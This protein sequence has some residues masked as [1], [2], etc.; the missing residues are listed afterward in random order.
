MFSQIRFSKLLQ[1]IPRHAFNKAV[2]DS[3]GDRYAK[4]FSSWD[5]LVTMIFGQVNQIQSLRTLSTAFGSLSAHHYHLNARSMSRSTLSDALSK[6]SP[7]PLRLLCEHL[8][9]GVARKQR[10]SIQEKICLIDSTSITLRGPGFDEWAKATKTRITQGLKVHMAIDPRQSAPT[11][12]NVTYANVNDMTDAQG[13][14]LEAD[15]TYVFD[16][17]Y[18]DYSWWHRIDQSGAFFVTRL[19]RNANVSHVK[20]HSSPTEKAENIERDEVVQFNNRQL[21]GRKNPYK[22]QAVR[23]IQ[24]KRDDHDPP[25]ILVTND[26]SRSAAEIAALYKDRWQIE[27]F[28]KWLK[29]KLNLK[30]YLGFSENAVRIQIYSALITYLLMTVY[31][32]RSDYQGSISEL[33][34][35]LAHC[36]FERPNT[37]HFLQL[38]RQRQE[39]ELNAIQQRIIFQ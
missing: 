17:G 19:K 20:E 2:Q 32:Q 29:Q 36:L 15:M 4:R 25:M 27:L 21:N 28:F 39:E 33:A 14:S 3:G 22:D 13:M 6:R 10:R 9:Q 5:L 7:E 34:I 31:L 8:L 11:Y 35:M 30:R 37:H 23:R 26:F 16:K 18:C 24:I 1:A 38:R 12:A